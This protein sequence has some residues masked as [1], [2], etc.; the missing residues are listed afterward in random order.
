MLDSSKEIHFAEFDLAYLLKILDSLETAFGFFPLIID[1]LWMEETD[2]LE[3]PS[4]I[5]GGRL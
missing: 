2:L 1:L 5:L 4:D 3:S